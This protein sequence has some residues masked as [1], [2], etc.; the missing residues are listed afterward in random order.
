MISRN[1]VLLR[2]DPGTLVNKISVAAIENSRGSNSIHYPSRHV[3]WPGGF[4][5]NSSLHIDE[6][7][8]TRSNHESGSSLKSRSFDT[9]SSLHVDEI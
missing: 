7:W 2:R 8:L 9:N 6:I 3:P 5:T 1:P 4:N